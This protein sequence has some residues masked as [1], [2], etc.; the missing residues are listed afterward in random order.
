MKRGSTLF[1]QVA[2][3]LI[4]IGAL[5]L[6]LWQPRLDGVEAHATLFQIYF[7]DLF[8]NYVYVACIPFFVALYQAFTLLKYITENKVFTLDSVKT[9]RII[10]HCAI[11][12][13]AFITV[14]EV[15]FFVVQFRVEEGIAKGFVIGLVMIFLSTVIATA[16]AVFERLLQ[17]AV[18]LKNENDLTV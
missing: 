3:V 13:V 10:K 12:I 8:Q 14:A 15:Y 6:I 1:L 9:L 18:E 4:G 16:T 11:M 5:A 17:S 7:T 2:I